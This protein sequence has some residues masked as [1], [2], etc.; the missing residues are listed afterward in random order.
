MANVP[1]REFSDAAGVR[2]RVWSTI[3]HLPGVAGAYQRGWL[4][5]ECNTARRRLAPIP[6]DWLDASLGQLREY[7]VTAEPVSRISAASPIRPLDRN[8]E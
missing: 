7:C 4:T 6:I 8:R 5:F 2:W 3:P 1:I